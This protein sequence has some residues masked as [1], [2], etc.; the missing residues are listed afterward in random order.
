MKLRKLA[1][2]FALI[3]VAGGFGAT[4]GLAHMRQTYNGVCGQ[5]N[6][7]PGL[8]QKMHFFAQGNCK[9]ASDGTCQDAAA[10]TI[11][12]PSGNIRG[13]CSHKVKPCTCVA[14]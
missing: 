8:L 7:V 2:A 10:C 12:S 14:D 5:L 9:V 6:G 11:S 3:L 4:S 1:M 13:K